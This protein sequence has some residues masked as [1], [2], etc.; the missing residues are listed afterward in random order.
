LGEWAC[1]A[2]QVIAPR[3]W[4]ATAAM[5]DRMAHWASVGWQVSTQSDLDRYTFG[6]A[7]SVGLM[8]CD[9]WAW[10][11]KIQI[12]RPHAVQFG[13]GLQAVNVLRNRD[14]DLARGVN[15]YPSGWDFDRMHRY[16]R[17]NL[18]GF[19]HYAESLPVT[20]FMSFVQI[21]RALAYA[22]LDALARG[23]PKL[24]RGAVLSIVSQLEAGEA[25]GG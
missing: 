8:L 3:I 2:P 24:T 21:P 17:S 16:A 13:R 20:T 15:F 18:D 11:E 14:E 10:F 7:G 9:L 22:T 25:A 1:Q 5:A 4:E 19:S 12:S 23:E 6:V